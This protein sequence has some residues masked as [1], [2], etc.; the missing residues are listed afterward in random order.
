MASGGVGCL[1]HVE[2]LVILVGWVVGA[3]QM[4]ML[5]P[6]WFGSEWPAHGLGRGVSI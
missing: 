3:T 6:H 2:R 5:L 4:R 1:G